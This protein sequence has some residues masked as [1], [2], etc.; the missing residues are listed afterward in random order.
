M[1]LN[2][3]NLL[4]NGKTTYKDLADLLEVSE[5]S[6]YSKVNEKTDFTFA[7]IKKSTSLFFRNMIFNTYL[8]VTKLREEVREH[9]V[10]RR[11]NLI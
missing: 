6:I 4:A 8:Q 9:E 11:E 2:L 5:K 7:E 3:K 1:L 10:Y